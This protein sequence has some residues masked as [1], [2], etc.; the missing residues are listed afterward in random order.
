M[1]QKQS[2][3]NLTNVGISHA[4]SQPSL[5][6]DLYHQQQQFQQPQMTPNPYG[7]LPHKSPHMFYGNPNSDPMA[8]VRNTYGGMP[9]VG[10]QPNQ[11]FF[12]SHLPENVSFKLF[13]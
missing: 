9:Y 4:T 6:N 10:S 7:T 5:Y 3:S 11:T 8:S 2:M 12:P 13:Y 1:Q